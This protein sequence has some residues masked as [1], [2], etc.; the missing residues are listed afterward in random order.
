M[1]PAPPD[2]IAPDDKNWTWVLERGCPDC[3]FDASSTPATDVARL[4]RENAAHWRQLLTH[5]HV[6]L[7]PT[8]DQ[9]SALEYGCHV[10]DVF[11]LYDVRLQLMLNEDGPRFPNWDQDATAVTD[12]YDL[13]DPAVV[14]EALVQAAA[15]LAARFE[16]VAA[17]Q[18]ARTGFRSDGAAFTVDSFARYF[19]HD[20]IHHLDDVQRGNRA[21]HDSALD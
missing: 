18:W 17:T 10:R 12:R 2:A 16:G 6:R 4:L 9:W 3:G 15:V 21:L 14:S 8:K 13:Q 19:I 1:D 11:R 5:P 20:P 7:R